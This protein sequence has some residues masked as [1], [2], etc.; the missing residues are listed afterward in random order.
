MNII[1]VVLV[2]GKRLFNNAL[3]LEGRTRVEALT[4]ALESLQL[5]QS[6]IIFCGGA[7]DGQTQTEARA[8]FD[9]FQL[10]YED[11]L[12]PHIILEDTSTNTIE[13]IQNAADKLIASQLCKSGQEVSVQF[14]SNDYH[15]K[16]IFEI[17]TLMN[18]QGLLRT[19]KNRCAESGLKLDIPMSLDAHVSVPYPHINLLGQIFLSLDEITTYRV[20]LEGVKSETFSRSLE[21]VRHQPYQI[22][23]TAIQKLKQLL[24]KYNEVKTLALIENAVEKTSP[25]ATPLEVVEQLRI[26][27]Q[28]LTNLNRQYD[29]ERQGMPVL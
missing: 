9:Y 14:V 22:A 15:L 11:E 28:C 27:D 25:S 3:T 18:E 24:S 23:M 6:A 21:Q 4:T 20:Y 2:L 17:Q 1:N 8:M 16:R 26:L 7:T 5:E 12:P 29:P 19:L 10:C 13:N